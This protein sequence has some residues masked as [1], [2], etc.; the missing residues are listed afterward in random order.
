MSNV[1]YIQPLSNKI[2]Q[3]SSATT[4]ECQTDFLLYL[5]GYHSAYSDNPA[6]EQ[7]SLCLLCQLVLIGLPEQRRVTAAKVGKRN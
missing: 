4:Q 7:Q 2:T 6:L 5:A 3:Y 1:C